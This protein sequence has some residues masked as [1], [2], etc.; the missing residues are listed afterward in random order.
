MAKTLEQILG[1]VA[2]TGTIK[3]TK[4]GVPNPFPAAFM[5]TTKKTIGDSGRYTQVTGTRRTAR[6]VMYGSPALKRELKDIASKDVKLIHTFE[7][8]SIPPLV[9]QNLRNYDNYEIQRMGMEE[10]ARQ[11]AE[12]KQLFENLRISALSQALSKGAV[13]FDGSG[14]FLPTSSGAVVTVDFGVPANN[15]N[16]LNGIIAASW[17]L[18]TTDIPLQLRTLKKTAAQLTGYPLKYAFYGENVPSYLTQNDYVLDYLARNPT[19]NA[20]FINAGEVGQLFDLTW[21]PVYTSFFEDHNGSNQALFGADQVSFT[22]EVSPDWYEMMEGTY[23]V[24]STL[25]IQTDAAA[26]VASMKQVTGMFGY[27]AVT[28]NPP[29]ICG[30]YGDTFLPIIKV[31]A[32]VFLADV[33]P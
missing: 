9:L 18:T 14:N 16:Q 7:E 32:A 29:S 23:M 31:P 33:T 24:P 25:D 28:H 17:A 4:T 11:V 12:F 22:P 15:L 2:L 1:Y 20:E 19:A 10:V 8:Q 30:Y 3:A 26:S 5:S 21:V 27:S 13:Y 6:Q